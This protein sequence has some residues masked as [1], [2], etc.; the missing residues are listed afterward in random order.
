MQSLPKT[1]VVVSLTNMGNNTL[2]LCNIVVRSLKCN[3][4]DMHAKE[5]SSKICGTQT[6]A[7]AIAVF[8]KYVFIK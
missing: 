3:G 2:K 8:K 5:I 7:E 4:Y 6:K 1:N